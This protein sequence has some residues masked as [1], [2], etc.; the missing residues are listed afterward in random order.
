MKFTT[1]AGIS[2]AALAA[3]SSVDAANVK[4]RRNLEEDADN[5]R[6]LS[7]GS[8]K[9]KGNDGS[10]PTCSEQLPGYS[11]FGE[12]YLED[13]FWEDLGDAVFDEG[14]FPTDGDEPEF[15]V[16][17]FVPGPFEISTGGNTCYD[18][19]SSLLFCGFITALS[20]I[21]YT[22]D[23]LR[24]LLTSL[25]TT[26]R[27]LTCLDRQHRSRALTEKQ[28]A[29]VERV[30]QVEAGSGPMSEEDILMNGLP[31]LGIDS[32]EDILEYFGVDASQNPFLSGIAR[33]RNLSPEIRG[34][35]DDLNEILEV[36]EFFE[37][38]LGFG[39]PDVEQAVRSNL[40]FFKCTTIFN[41]GLGLC[42]GIFALLKTLDASVCYYRE[43][44]GCGMDT[45][46][47]D[48]N[49]DVDYLAERL[50]VDLPVPLNSEGFIIADVLAPCGACILEKSG[51]CAPFC[52]LYQSYHECDNVR[53]A[54]L[55]NQLSGLPLGRGASI[56]SPINVMISAGELP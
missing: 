14:D 17:Y 39:D 51:G 21:I 46:T 49:F 55:D 35:G 10:C 19:E 48:L 28:N 6:K 7:K 8:S 3:V 45:C 30:L 53:A 18:D 12:N 34:K 38:F 16:D 4:G 47:K 37:D 15:G 27:D 50:F 44:L 23:L 33:R 31:L 11:F 5:K 29:G 54:Y 13:S 20:E 42:A 1:L 24:C 2:L 32:F 36:D 9:S 56:L 41:L 22:N 52:Q 43:E 25:A 26:L 40:F